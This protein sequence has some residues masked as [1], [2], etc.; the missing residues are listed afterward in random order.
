MPASLGGCKGMIGRCSVSLR[1]KFMSILSDAFGRLEKVSS[2]CNKLV[3]GVMAKCSKVG[4]E[5]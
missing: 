1:L 2:P 3:K 4:R 5:Q